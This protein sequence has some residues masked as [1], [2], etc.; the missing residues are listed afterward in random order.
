MFSQPVFLQNPLLLQPLGVFLEYSDDAVLK[1]RSQET[2][3]RLFHLLQYLAAQIGLLSN[4]GKCQ[5]LCIHS[6]LPISLSIWAPHAL[7]HFVLFSSP[8]KLNS[9]HLLFHS[10]LSHHLNILVFYHSC[11]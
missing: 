4:G 10:L 8:P 2:M 5:L 11:I 7:A 6:F 1:S 9:H 3:F